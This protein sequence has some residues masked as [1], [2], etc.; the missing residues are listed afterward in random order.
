MAYEK[1]LFIKIKCKKTH[2]NVWKSFTIFDP[3]LTT[4]DQSTRSQYAKDKKAQRKSRGLK[5]KFKKN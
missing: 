5:I 2:E 3:P 4:P 1:R